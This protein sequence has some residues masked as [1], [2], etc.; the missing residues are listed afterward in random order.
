MS[1]V[2]GWVSGFATYLVVLRVG[3]GETLDGSTLQVFAFWS[4]VV[5][6]VAV[7]LVY[8]P[9]MSILRRRLRG[10]RPLVAFPLVAA[11]VGTL[12]ATLMIY[13]TGL[14]LTPEAAVFYG[15]FGIAGVAFGAGFS[16]GR[17]PAS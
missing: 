12:P 17:E 14:L 7:L 16:V 15:C 13:A 3:Y 5:F 2:L 10:Y 9:A 6:A 4:A 11:L 8:A 1:T